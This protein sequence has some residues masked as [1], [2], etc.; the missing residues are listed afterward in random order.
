[1][2][3]AGLLTS[4]LLDSGG[5]VGRGD[6]DLDIRLVHSSGS[7]TRLDLNFPS[8]YFFPRLASSQDDLSA[9]G[10]LHQQAA[11]LTRPIE[12]T[13]TSKSLSPFSATR[14]LV[15]SLIMRS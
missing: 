2:Q 14:P 3:Q 11:P 10:R 7:H 5:V 12:L 1:M 15:L 6:V 8:C 4:Q 9:R 13:A